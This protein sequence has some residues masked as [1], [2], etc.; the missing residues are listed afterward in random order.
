MAFLSLLFSYVLTHYTL[1]D[2]AFRPNQFI[3]TN[4]IY[5]PMITFNIMT[6]QKIFYFN[7]SIIRIK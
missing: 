6:K 2:T 5:R 4:I 1:G 3:I 7:F